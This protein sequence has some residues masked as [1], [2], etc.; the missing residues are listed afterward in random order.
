MDNSAG[1]LNRDVYVTES[2][3]GRIAIFAPDGTQLGA[4]DG[5]TN[6]S[7]GFSEACG[8]AV[9]E[10]NGSLY[11][12]DYGGRIWRYAP[13][14]P[15]GEINDADYTVSGINVGNDISP[16]NVA[17]D[18]G[19]VYASGWSD[20]PLERYSASSF[21]AGAPPVAAGTK[22]SEASLA[23]ATDSARHYVYVN[24]GEQIS[25]FDPSGSVVERFASGEFFESRGIAVRSSDN[26]VFAIREREP[27]SRIR[28]RHPALRAY[29]QHRGGPRPNP[30]RN[31]Q[32]RRFPGDSR[33]SLRCLRHRPATDRP[34]K[35]RLLRGLPLRHP[36]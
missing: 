9:D 20:G 27:S 7:G 21:A 35:Q 10:S 23:L 28:V 14:S 34:R 32:L 4:I 5:S 30:A 13:N 8:V 22:I 31:T 2:S 18:N 19:L 24:E 12:G 15:S 33:W 26:H 6:D 17:A 36:E 29:R 11:V 3:A 16:C 25:V 1:A